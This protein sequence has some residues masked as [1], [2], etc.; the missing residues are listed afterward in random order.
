MRCGRGSRR[1]AEL[2]SGRWPGKG[3]ALF[4]LFSRT[5]PV[6]LP[7]ARPKMAPERDMLF[8]WSKTHYLAERDKGPARDASNVKR[9]LVK[10]TARTFRTFF[11]GGIQIFIND[12]GVLLN[13]LLFLMGNT[14]FY[15]GFKPGPVATRRIDEE[16]DWPG[17]NN[18]E[19]RSRGRVAMMLLSQRFRTRTIPADQQSGLVES[20]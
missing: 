18:P 6:D 14:P 5:S 2:G 1:R 8:V 15:E 11:K 12:F 19:R 17:P 16:F 4:P 3:G 9:E 20:K 7:S 13:D 10:Y